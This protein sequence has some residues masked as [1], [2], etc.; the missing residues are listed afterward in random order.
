MT[1]ERI[2]LSQNPALLPTVAGW[3]FTE[4]GG[5]VPGRTEADECQRLEVFLHDA[6]LPLLLI[7]LEDGQPVAAA[8]LKFHERTE[9]PERQHW[10]GGVYVRDSHRGRGIA[11]VLIED[12][13]TRA[14]ALGVRDVYL[15]TET[16]D[17]GLYRRLGWVPLESVE[18]AGGFPVRIMLRRLAPH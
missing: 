12:L 7:A 8:Q 4:W 17:G 14:A 11:A 15:Q 10:L 2:L 9:R 5:H 1:I 13:M 6:A 18:H 16:D 3:Y